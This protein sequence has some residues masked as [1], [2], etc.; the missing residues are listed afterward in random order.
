[1]CMPACV[2][3][4][5]DISLGVMSEAASRVFPL[6]CAAASPR[7]LQQRECELRGALET[8]KAALFLDGCLGFV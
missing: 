4:C 3:K 2:S 6:L 8:R 1:M 5:M 7:G